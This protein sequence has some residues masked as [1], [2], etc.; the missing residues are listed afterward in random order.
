[1][2]HY[3]YITLAALALVSCNNKKA[4]APQEAPAGVE[5]QPSATVAVDYK[6]PEYLS[7][8]LAMQ[9]LGGQVRSMVFTAL[10]CDP[11]GNLPEGVEFDPEQAIF[12]EYDTNGKFTKGYAFSG[13]EKGPKM[14]RDEKGRVIQ[15]ERLIAEMNFTYTNKFTYNDDGTLAS[16]EVNGLEHTGKTVNTYT[17]GVL[18]SAVATG[19]GEGMVYKTKSDFKVIEVDGHGNWTKRLSTNVTE[20]GPDDGTGKVTETSTSYGLEIRQIT[21]YN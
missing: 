17:D 4:K 2:K 10:E 20:S 6:A 8:D 3:I 15:L 16:D 12:F 14:I 9:E 7:P 13:E 19:A 11:N 1:M 18:T 5:A 21:Y